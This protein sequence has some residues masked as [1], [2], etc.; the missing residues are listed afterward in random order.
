MVDP[1]WLGL[2]PDGRLRE[3]FRAA[4]VECVVMR[5]SRLEIFSYRSANAV[6]SGI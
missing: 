2:V 6:M 1:G 4:L 3:E 5:G